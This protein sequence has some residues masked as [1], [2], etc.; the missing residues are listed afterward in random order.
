MNCDIGEGVGFD[1]EILKWITSANIACGA[2]AGDTET[3]KITVAG[4]LE[5][6]VKI[7]AH[8]GYNDKTNFGRVVQQL[9]YADLVDLVGTQIIK[10]ADLCHQQ[11]TSIN[12]IKPHGALYNLAMEDAAT[13]Q[14][15]VDAIYIISPKYI[16]FG[17]PNSIFLT[18]AQAKGLITKAE[19][20]IDRSYQANGKLTP[21]HEPHA[22]YH[23]V[24]DCIWQLKNMCLRQQIPLNNN[25]FI[26]CHIDTVCLH[27][28]GAYI[29][30][31]LKSSVQF[32]KEHHLYEK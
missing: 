9:H 20:F 10:L 23:E 2:H 18:L 11:G 8:P 7:G 16:V 21:R 28:D 25:Q 12:H 31:F 6:N 22:V 29:I 24:S 27:G 26:P 1:N 4:C 5:N 19:G 3:M 15:V 13:A 17:L 30:P 32:L 14:A